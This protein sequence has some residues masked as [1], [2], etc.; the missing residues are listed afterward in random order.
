MYVVEP[1]GTFENDPNVTDKK[2]PGN[3]TRSCGSTEPLQIVG[4]VTDWKRQSP[5]ALQMRRDRLTGI[6]LDECT[7]ITN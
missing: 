4:E 2:L 3:P 1:T 6:R 5:E 7:K